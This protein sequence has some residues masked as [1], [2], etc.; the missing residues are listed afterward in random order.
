M[1]LF[2]APTVHEH[3]VPRALHSALDMMVELERY[4]DERNLDLGLHFGINTGMVVAGS[5]GSRSDRAYSVIGDAV[6]IA[7]RLKGAAERR[8]RDGVG[9]GLVHRAG[10]GGCAPR[11]GLRDGGAWPGRVRGGRR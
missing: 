10:T 11:G 2:G 3:D 7:A 5:L 8:S 6:N 4:N 1:A 9:P